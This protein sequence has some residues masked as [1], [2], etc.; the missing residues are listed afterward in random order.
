MTA[1]NYAAKKMGGDFDP[2]KSFNNLFFGAYEILNRKDELVIDPDLE[3]EE[4]SMELPESMKNVIP[5]INFGN[6]ECATGFYFGDES[7]H[8]GN[9]GAFRTIEERDEICA[10]GAEQLKNLVKQMD[11]PNYVQC[12]RNQDQYTNTVIRDKFGAYLP[13]MKNAEWK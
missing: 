13:K 12:L 8:G 1:I 4:R 10:L 5:L 3:V 9:S 2:R 6:F 7:D 11:M